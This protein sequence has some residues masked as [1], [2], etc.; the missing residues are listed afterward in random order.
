MVCAES[1]PSQIPDGKDLIYEGIATC[2][3]RHPFSNCILDGKDLIYE[4]IATPIVRPLM[5]T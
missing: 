2:P 1:N 3:A 5:Q 4:G